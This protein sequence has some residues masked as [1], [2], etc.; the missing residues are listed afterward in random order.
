MIII[1]GIKRTVALIRLMV[2]ILPYNY[3][4][5]IVN[6]KLI[7]CRKYVTG[8]GVDSLRRSVMKEEIFG[9]FTKVLL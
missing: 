9:D 6:W 1:R 8:R 7:Q 2:W 5:N 3:D 4:L